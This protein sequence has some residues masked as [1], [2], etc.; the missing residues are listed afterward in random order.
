[1]TQKELRKAVLR[2]P[3]LLQ[4]SVQENLRRKLEYFV[5]ELSIPLDD[6]PL[7]IT[8]CPAIWGLSLNES[9]RPKVNL[10]MEVCGLSQEEVGRIVTRSPDILSRS[11]KRS[12]EPTLDYLRDRLSLSQSELRKVIMSTPRVLIHSI[13]SS[14]EPKLQSIENVL[15]NDGSGENALKV[16][17]ENPALLVKSNDVL[18][19]RLN[20]LLN[21]DLHEH[22]KSKEKYVQQALRRGDRS[23]RKRQVLEMDPSSDEVIREFVSVTVAANELKTSQVNVYNIINT[24]RVWNGRKLVYG[25]APSIEQEAAFTA[26]LP[27]PISDEDEAQL[28]KKKPLVFKDLKSALKTSVDVRHHS[29]AVDTDTVRIA[30]YVSGRVY[31]PDSMTEVRGTRRAGGMV[32]LFPQIQDLHGPELAL[33]LR[34]AAKRSF[35][36]IMP[37]VEEGGG[38]TCYNDGRILIG[39]PYLRPSRNRCELYACHEAIKVVAQLLK[40]ESSLVSLENETVQVDVY[41]DS[42]YSWKLL[43]NST[44]LLH[45]G[46]TVHESDFVYDGPGPTWR[47]NPDLL[48]PLCRTYYRLVQQQ[49]SDG[50]RLT[51]GKQVNVTFH[52]AAGSMTRL[53]KYAMEAAMWMHQRA[54]TAIK[55]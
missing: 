19:K 15:G 37:H 8:R 13:K 2:Q 7:V 43:H 21:E 28:L 55:L 52:H 24:G 31:P 1:M 12:L 34:L 20:R 10:L 38:G 36:Q 5:S 18:Q 45:W 47:A 51:L 46:A 16:V 42:D 41:T 32:L 4:Y 14:L 53:H 22:S 6:M 3:S 26:S 25:T 27:S 33:R 11:L 50:T 49:D 23:R 39:F 9:L 40:H 44:R 17:T 48:H 54:Q 29:P 35:G 30:V